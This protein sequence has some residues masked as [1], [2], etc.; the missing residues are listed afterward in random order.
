M[1]TI[2]PLMSTATERVPCSK[3]CTWYQDEGQVSRHCAIFRIV[4]AIDFAGSQSSEESAEASD[5]TKG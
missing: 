2:C 5:T 3:Q 4:D 1:I